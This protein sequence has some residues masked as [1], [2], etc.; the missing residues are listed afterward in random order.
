MAETLKDTLSFF[1]KIFGIIRAP[2]L[3]L[4]PACVILGLAAAVHSSGRI[5]TF[6]FLL[7]LVGALCA[8]I[9]VNTLNEYFDFK[10]GLDSRTH[11]T[12]FSGGSGTLQQNPSFAAA[13]LIIAFIAIIL[14]VVIGL[15]FSLLRGPAII[16]LGI[17]GLI[18]VVFYTLRITRYPVL[19][20]IAPGLG[21]GIFMVMGTNFALTG[22][23][24]WSS[25]IASLVPFFLVNNLLLLNQYPDTDAD[26]TVGRRHLP[27]VIGRTKSSYIYALFLLS[28]YLSIIAGIYLKY[29]PIS[30]LL[31]LITIPPAILAT[32]GVFR[33]AENIEKLNTYLALNVIIIIA[34]PLLLSA[35][36]MLN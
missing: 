15:Y 2:F 30:G 23:Y 16:P 29:F 24:T 21:F 12:P 20:L 26:K 5:S 8:H 6:D 11:R 35:G 31:G 36:L 32:I 33:D 9:S 18:L 7:A 3:I 25:F 1:K 28:A 22:K 13:A 27:I 4:T 10:S 34:T 17:M 14:I 19:C